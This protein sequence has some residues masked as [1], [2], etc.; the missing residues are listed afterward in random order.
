[1]TKPSSLPYSSGT[2]QTLI[3]SLQNGS[4]VNGITFK[5]IDKKTGRVI[6]TFQGAELILTYYSSSSIFTG[7]MI[8]CGYYTGSGYNTP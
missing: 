5:K 2:A 4:V 3:R 6:N 8:S 7:G 1:M